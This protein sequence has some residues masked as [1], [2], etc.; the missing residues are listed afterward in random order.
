MKGKVSLNEFNGYEALLIKDIVEFADRKVGDNQDLLTQMQRLI[1]SHEYLSAQ[2]EDIRAKAHSKM[3]QIWKRP[4][5]EVVVWFRDLKS[6]KRDVQRLEQEVY[7]VESRV[8]S[9]VQ[10]R[11]IIAEKI[12]EVAEL[13]DK[14]RAFKDNLLVDAFSIGRL[15]MPPT[16]DIFESAEARDPERI[17]EY[18]INTLLELGDGDVWVARTERIREYLLDTLSEL[19]D[20]DVWAAHTQRIREY[21]TDTLSEVRD[22]DVWVARTK[23]IWEYLIDTLLEPGDGDVWVAHTERIREYLTD[24][25]LEVGNGDVTE[26][27]REYLM[28]TLS[29]LRDDAAT[30][31]IWESLTD[32]LSKLRDGAVIELREYSKLGDGAMWVAHTERIR[33]N[34]T[35]TLSE[36]RDGDVW[37]ARTERIRENLTDTL[38]EL[39]DDAVT[40][41]R[42]YSKLGDGVVQGT[43]QAVRSAIQPLLE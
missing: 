42:E 32:K 29:K 15:L 17:R 35:N 28:D 9:P 14:G 41:L 38:S 31:R 12:Q 21:L 19:G 11:K 36:L 39:R 10:L 24:T 6:L 5:K 43:F 34:L 27:F 13:R 3:L 2:A 7:F 25:L 8:R 26:R 30:E 16:K 22:G 4:K 33:E 20:D 18:L 37:V 1:T 23:R 40:E